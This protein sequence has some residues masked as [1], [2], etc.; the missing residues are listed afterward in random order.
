MFAVK[1]ANGYVKFLPVKA[2]PEKDSAAAKLY[3]LNF[4]SLADPNNTGF[5]R[6]SLRNLRPSIRAP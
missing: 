6:Q 2:P 5:T 3:L 1:V 4:R